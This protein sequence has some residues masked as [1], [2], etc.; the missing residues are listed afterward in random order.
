MHPP[1]TPCRISVLALLLELLCASSLTAHDFWVQPKEYW[2]AQDAVSD[3]TLQVGHGAY[4]QRSP[5]P[6]RR[7]TR[8]EAIAP[9]GAAIDLR[10]TLH[11][12]DKADDGILRFGAPGTYVLVLETDDRAQVH[13]PAIRFNDYLQHEGLTPAIEQRRRTHRT[14]ADGSE[15]YS[16]CVKSIIQVGAPDAKPQAQ[17]SK[18]LGLPLEIVLER[19]PYG[20]P[21][22]ATLPVRVFYEGQLLKGALVKLTNLEHDD[23][24][25]A[26]QIT[27]NAGR[28]IFAM[29]TAGSW[30]LNVIWTKTQPHS[31]DT[32]FETIFSSFSF[33]FPHPDP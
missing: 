29:P 6:L 7:I 28:A 19:N 30:L 25:F 20:E 27:D 33:G 26:M 22:S 11:L 9:N 2:L 15:Q 16:R 23:A 4:R 5:I 10:E 1:P 17:L 12:G 3:M 14:D 21:R 13:L 32:D 8:Y 18:P 24:P 31:S